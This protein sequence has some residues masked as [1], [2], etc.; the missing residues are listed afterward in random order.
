[1]VAV[2]LHAVESFGGV[3]AD[4]DPIL[5]DAFEEHPAYLGARD[6]K[7]TLI[8]GRKGSGKTAI[9]KKL[10]STKSYDTFTLGFTFRNYPWDHHNLQKQSGVSAEECYR[11]SWIYFICLSAATIIVHED[12]STSCIPGTMDLHA[13]LRSF[14]RDSF[15]GTR[16][17]L[18]SIFSPQ[19][20]FRLGGRF[21]LPGIGFSTDVVEARELPTFY[22][23]INDFILSSV[24]K[25]LNPAHH[26]YLCFDELDFGFEPG[27]ADYC[28][29]LVGLIRAATDVNRKARDCGQKLSVII[30]LRDDIYKTINFEDKNKILPPQYMNVSWNQGGNTNTLREL[31][32]KR[33]QVV[34]GSK[35]PIKWGDLFDEEK[36]M[37]GRQSKY[38]YI[39]DRTFLRPR[40]IIAF[41]NST[42]EEYKSKSTVNLKVSNDEVLRGEGRYSE[43]LYDELA[44][45][46]HKHFP[47]YREVFECIREVEYMAFSIKQFEESWTRFCEQSPSNF[48]ALQALEFLYNFSIVGFHQRGGSGG[49]T[50]LT[51]KYK[52]AT[53]MFDR[54]AVD[55]KVHPGLKKVLELKKSRKK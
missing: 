23:Q 54:R 4:D 20:R 44:D 30:F 49:G 29:R 50:K 8:S 40:D 37:G 36:E 12:E 15:G 16:P 18:N 45:E 35:T 28:N 39:C 7:T 13:Q 5:I 2:N 42:L 10:L 32:E 14:L 26:Y 34:L 9:F 47:A 11:N 27:N 3:A 21:G 24:V 46:V 33:F 41:C 22:S 19:R 17:D 25:C 38:N 43:F 1:M 55:F 31:M 53:R 48:T 51:W 52:E 6:L